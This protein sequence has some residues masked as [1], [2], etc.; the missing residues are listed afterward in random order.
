MA[1]ADTESRD[2]EEGGY[3]SAP[4]GLTGRQMSSQ[5]PGTPGSPKP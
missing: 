1:A 2:W 5:T 4:L 3:G